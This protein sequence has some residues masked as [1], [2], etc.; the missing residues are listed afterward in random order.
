MLKCTEV[1]AEQQRLRR[2]PCGKPLA[3]R[4]ALFN[5]RL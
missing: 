1:S 3:F 5:W 2:L 4:R